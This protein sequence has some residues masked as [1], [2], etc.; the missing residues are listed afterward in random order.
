MAAQKR[1]ARG[2]KVAGDEENPTAS[3]PGE[4]P[5]P[6][7]ATRSQ[8]LIPGAELETS[9]GPQEVGAT[10]GARAPVTRV[11]RGSRRPAAVANLRAP[12]DP[13]QQAALDEQQEKAEKWA[14]AQK[15]GK[16]V[17]VV[18]TRTGYYAGKRR[19]A[20]AFFAMAIPKG[21]DLPSWVELADAK[22][23]EDVVL[24]DVVEAANE[25]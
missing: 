21:E 14:E 18:A 22:A 11:L 24:E 6:A 17:A 9:S 12:R 4:E 2:G 13:E 3:I 19:R 25:A 10:R 8:G 20:G 7:P 15:A 16:G 5:F 1:G 23:R